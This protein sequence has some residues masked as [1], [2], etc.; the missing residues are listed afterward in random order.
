VLDLA[1]ASAS[2]LPFLKA[3]EVDSTRK[4]APK[5]VVVRGGKVSLTYS[6][7][8]PLMV[9]LEMPTVEEKKE[10]VTTWN[11]NKPGGWEKYKESSDEFAE[12]IEDIVESEQ[13]DIGK[14]IKKI[15]AIQDKIKHKVFGKTR[16]K[17][18]VKVIETGGNETEE[19][20]AKKLLQ[21]QSKRIEAEIEEVRKSKQG[22]CSNIF[23]MKEIVVGKKKAN[24]EAAA[25]K[26]FKTG[27]LVV[28]NKD[29]KEKTLFAL[30]F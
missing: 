7:H 20:E 19:E 9:E 15:D 10:K 3:V 28:S 17:S 12:K 23:K 5:R 13:M 30:M 4:V 8:F 25:I 18:N 27:K 24:K 22:R 11:V 21:L 14:V 6:D 26:D 29:I 16:V 2:L 1:I